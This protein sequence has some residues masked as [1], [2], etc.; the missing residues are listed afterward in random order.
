MFSPASRVGA[1]INFQPVHQDY[2][3]LNTAKR[4]WM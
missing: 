2:G 4:S 1:E 3:P